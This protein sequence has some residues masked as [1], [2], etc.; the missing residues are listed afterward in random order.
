M[1]TLSIA[2]AGDEPPTEFRI[3][4]AGTVET[5]KGT[6]TFDAASAAAVMAEYA[7]HGTDV[8]IDYDHAALAELAIDPALA[9]R[10]AG[11]CGLEVRNGELWAVN[12]RWTPPAAEA[13][14]AKEWRY[15]SPAFTH[16]DGV[17]NGLLNVAITN[18]PATRNLEP[19]IAAS[20]L[21]NVNMDQVVKAG[22]ISGKLTSAAL[23]AVANKDAKSALDLLKQ[24]L[25]EL[26][27]GP[28]GGDAPPAGDAP[29]ADPAAANAKPGDEVAAA[30]AKLAA[31]QA[32]LAADTERLEIETARAKL[33]ADRAALAAQQATLDAAAKIEIGAQMVT[34]A[35]EAPAAVWADANDKAKG[36]K[37]YLA[38]MSTADL[39]AMLADK[40]ASRGKSPNILPPAGEAAPSGGAT[41]NTPSGPVTLSAREVAMCA[42]MKIKPEDYAANKAANTKKAS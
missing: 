11:W 33:D 22:A 20:R 39:R 8:M 30:R 19:L 34:L 18:M 26:L 42:E 15:M 36:L 23:E 13:L 35:G 1:A 12:V 27:G 24:L 6:F 40:I 28:E 32:K 3:F 5:S 7:K 10:A 16:R 17:I 31:D 4:T 14:K 29:A 37:P 9:G 25:G 2:V 21:E 41:V 38:S